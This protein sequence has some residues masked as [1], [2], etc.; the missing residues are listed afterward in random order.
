[1]KIKKQI[2]VFIKNGGDLL[3]KLDYQGALKYYLQA[4]K[5]AKDNSLDKNAIFADILDGIGKTYFYSDQYIKSKK[6]AF[7][8]KEIR[9]KVF[10]EI[11]LKTAISYF[12]ISGV[13]SHFGE[14]EK[15]LEYEKKLVSI[16][17]LLLGKN[18]LDIAVSYDNMAEMYK[19]LMQDKEALK[20]KKKALGL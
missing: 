20:Y 7:E 12:N 8:A 2:K 18:H 11:H 16:R 1:M 9:E 10:G 17:K 19:H 3:E 4:K 6:Y 15:A 13:Y 5:L 14:F